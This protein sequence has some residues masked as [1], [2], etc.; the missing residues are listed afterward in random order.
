M[1]QR[2]KVVI[3]GEP[4]ALGTVDAEDETT[5]LKRGRELLEAYRRRLGLEE[6]Q[7]DPEWLRVV[8][9]DDD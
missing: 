8:P 6:R 1:G 3:A 2:W 5:A 4:V 9:S 7:L